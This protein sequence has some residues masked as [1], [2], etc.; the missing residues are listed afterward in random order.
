MIH[1]FF[2][3]ET[4]VTRRLLGLVD[5][6]RNPLMLCGAHAA[7]GIDVRHLE[8]LRGFEAFAGDLVDSAVAVDEGTI[9]GM[10]RDPV[11]DVCAIIFPTKAEA[12]AAAGGYVFLQGRK[13]MQVVK[14]RTGDPLR[15]LGALCEFARVTFDPERTPPPRS[16]PRVETP[17]SRRRA[18]R[19][20]AA[21]P[22]IDDPF[23]MLGIAR[24][25][26]LDEARSAYRSLVVKY[27]PD[28]VA[29]LADEFRELA[30]RRTREINSAFDEVERQLRS[31]NG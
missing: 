6:S 23:V 18:P 1:V 10:W 13:P 22:G 29:H 17:G 20:R 11:G 31:G 4:D 14:K 27:H 26:S 12:A 16:R 28:K 9:E 24:N 15:D 30:E 8:P 19:P 2:H 5:S 21:E 7:P 3:R 25:A